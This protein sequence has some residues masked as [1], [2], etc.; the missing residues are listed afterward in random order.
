[1]DSIYQLWIQFPQTFEFNE[2]YLLFV[3]DHFQSSLFGNF[4]GNSD[5]DR[6]V[7]YQVQELTQSIWAYVEEYRDLFVNTSYEAY[8]GP[9]WPQTS[10]HRIKLWERFW[11]RW[12]MTAHPNSLDKKG[13][14]RDDW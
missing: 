12:D 1:M 3:A 6:R 7:E 13:A 11:L 8:A 4:L 14:W 2:A 10:M 9:I 5:R